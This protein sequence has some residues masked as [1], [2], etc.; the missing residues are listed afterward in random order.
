MKITFVQIPRD[1][2]ARSECASSLPKA[3]RNAN[4]SKIIS[5]PHSP[6]TK[7]ELEKLFSFAGLQH[8]CVQMPHK[9]CPLI[10]ALHPEHMT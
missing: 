6:K 5:T 10:H 7:P 9:S 4:R 3:R 2:G 8:N 1:P